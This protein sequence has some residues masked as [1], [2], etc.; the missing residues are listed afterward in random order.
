MQ[1]GIILSPY[2]KIP[3][4]F[5]S[6]IQYSYGGAESLCPEDLLYNTRGEVGFYGDTQLGRSL[7]TDFD[8][9][10]VY[11]W[12]PM[13]DGGVASTD[14]YYPG[15]WIP[16]NGWNPAD[17]YGA[18]FVP[19]GLGDPGAIDTNT[20]SVVAT[21]EDQNKKMFTLQFIATLAVATSAVVALMR[22]T[23]LFRK[24]RRS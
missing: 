17:P 11:G 20:A 15:G 5:P 24:E 16:P 13:H 19:K 9:A 21:M 23:H 8:V 18:H 6:G 10:P 4:S 2:G 12:T 1:L 22:N 14:G 3:G 7:V